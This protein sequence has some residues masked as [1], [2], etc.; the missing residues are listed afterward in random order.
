MITRRTIDQ[1]NRPF[2]GIVKTVIKDRGFGFIT[3]EF[4]N[5]IYFQLKECH[6]KKKAPYTYVAFKKR[7]S[8]RT[9]KIEAYEI[10]HISDYKSE[11]LDV[12]DCLLLSERALVY[13]C[14][15]ELLDN[16]IAEITKNE[17]NALKNINDYINSIN[18]DEIIESYSV[19]V[20]SGY[21]NKP[22]N[23]DTAW[24]KYVAERK[25]GR[26]L[27]QNGWHYSGWQIDVYL[28]KI[29]PEYSET[30][31]HE[32]AFC[33]GE[34][35]LASFGNLSEYRKKAEEETNCTRKKANS[36][37]NKD[38]HKAYL[39]EFLK[40][41]INEKAEEYKKGICLQLQNALSVLKIDIKLEDMKF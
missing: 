35:I 10:K 22:G 7:V 27:Y 18:I 2:V 32:S 14:N 4:Q 37:Y 29:L 6:I 24:V 41:R 1:L 30:I 28:N 34:S 25:K 33:P 39:I 12:I 17:A 26:Y 36:L 38:E 21:R 15:K 3:I 9:Q 19:Q 11:L 5:D 23:D 31:F 40:Q 16:K 20:I 8:P 13:Y